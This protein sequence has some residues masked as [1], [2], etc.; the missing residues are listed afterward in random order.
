MTMNAPVGPPMDTRVPPSAEMM[1]PG[2]DRRENARLGLDA[3]GNRKGHRQRQRHNADREP[4]DAI[5]QE[6]LA[7]IGLKRWKTASGEMESQYA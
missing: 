6:I 1:K 3:R 4:G 5:R 2:D 7:G